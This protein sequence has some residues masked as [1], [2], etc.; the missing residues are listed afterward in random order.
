MKKFLLTAI[1]L[2]G[3]S[4]LS[5]AQQGRVG[6][7]TTA[8]AATLDVVANTTDNARPDALLVPRMTRAQLLA[9]DAAYTA[10]QNGALAFVTTIDGTATPKTTN[11]TAVGF[12]YYDGQTTNTWITVGGGGSV[13]PAAPSVRISTTGSDLSAA[14]LNGYV[15]I[16]TAG[17]VNLATIPVSAATKGKTVTIV[18]IGSTNV[19]I[20]GMNASSV[21]SITVQ[22]RGIA[23]VYDG[24]AWQS[25]SVN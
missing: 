23:F 1:M 11:V 4:A 13:T 10:A 2:V 20:T 7:N 6:I 14:D 22:G 19:S 18:R 8:P 12:Y 21:N 24:T 3:L 9:K 17:S 16:D 5:K 15:F 25:Y